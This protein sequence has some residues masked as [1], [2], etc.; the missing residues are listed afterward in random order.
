VQIEIGELP[1]KQLLVVH[2]LTECD[3][4]SALFG[5]GKNGLTCVS[6]CGDCHGDCCFNAGQPLKLTTRLTLTMIQILTL[7]LMWQMTTQLVLTGVGKM[8]KK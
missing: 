3:T 7:R 2:A 1:V 4:T 8:K 6:A 5:Q